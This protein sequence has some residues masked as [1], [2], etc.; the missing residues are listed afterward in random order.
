VAIAVR[1]IRH[2]A[3]WLHAALAVAVVVAVFVQVYLIGGYLFGAGAGALDAH[4]SV[5]FI[6]HSIELAIAA[7]ALVAWL[8][9][10]QIILSI[11][12]A[13]VGTA[14]VSLADAHRWVGALHPLG[15]L[16][17]LIL[18]TRIAWESPVGSRWRSVRTTACQGRISY[19]T[20]LARR[21]RGS[22]ERDAARMAAERQPLAW[23]SGA[24]SR[25]IFVDREGR[26]P[27]RESGTAPVPAAGGLERTGG[28]RRWYDRGHR[29]SPCEAQ[30]RARRV[31]PSTTTPCSQ[32]M[33]ELHPPSSRP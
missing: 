1:R 15:A 2:G 32:V 23:H 11:V 28:R 9:R 12:L 4:K 18:A 33:C 26:I 20:A 25:Q 17:V 8:P 29:P 13:V 5:G 24:S 14:Q 30:I 10:A 27:G 6:A 31:L 3:A 7:M 21:G 19:L 22:S 16:V